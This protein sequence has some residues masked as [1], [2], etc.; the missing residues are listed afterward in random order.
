MRKYIALI[1]ILLFVFIS[2]VRNKD[3]ISTSSILETLDLK[4]FQNQYKLVFTYEG[5]VF[6]IISDGSGLKQL[7]NDKGD[8]DPIWSQSGEE[9]FFL[10]SGSRDVFKM[11][12]DGSNRIN[13]SNTVCLC[14]NIAVSPD[15]LQVLYTEYCNDDSSHSLIVIDLTNSEKKV[16]IQKNLILDPI[17]FPGGSKIL[18][19]ANDSTSCGGQFVCSDLY[20][21]DSN[22][23]NLLQLTYTVESEFEP[24]LSPS[25]DKIAYWCSKVN[26]YESNI[27]IMD[28]DG[29]NAVKITDGNRDFHP[30]WSPD[31]SKII[32]KSIQDDIG[33]VFIIN[34][35]GSDL[36][37]ISEGITNLVGFHTLS[38]DGT[39]ISFV[40]DTDGDF[41]GDA[42]YILDIESGNYQKLTEGWSSAQWANLRIED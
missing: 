30:I 5:G 29:K 36:K 31:G 24:A 1:C 13:L 34:S 12:A 4:N 8:F 3:P 19:S 17:W 9:I 7:S 27:Y 14:D 41:V 18:F 26:G 38:P 11:N 10:V 16:L 39:R 40:V 15:G 35:D 20:I 21:I 22:G 23:E 6:S 33:A 42:I 25:A 2:C 37:N 32:F 28:M